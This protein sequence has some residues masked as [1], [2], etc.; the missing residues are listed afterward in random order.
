VSPEYR[1]TVPVASPALPPALHL[2]YPQ[3]AARFPLSKPKM[4][5]ALCISTI[6]LIPTLAVSSL[7]WMF[8]KNG[9]NEAVI[10][11]R[12]KVDLTVAKTE[13]A[14]GL[15]Q[16]M[17]EYELLDN[18]VNDTDKNC[19]NMQSE[20]DQSVSAAI[21]LA[22]VTVDDAVK[23]LFS[24]NFFSVLGLVFNEDFQK[25]V[26]AVGLEIF[27]L[28]KIK[29]NDEFL[30][31]VKKHDGNVPEIITALEARTFN[32]LQP[33]VEFV[34]P[35]TQLV[36][37]EIVERGNDPEFLERVKRGVSAEDVWKHLFGRIGDDKSLIS[38]Q[39]KASFDEHTC[40]KLRVEIHTIAEP[41]LTD[42][43]ML[44][45]MFER[46]GGFTANQ[47]FAAY[48][49]D[50][51]LAYA[52]LENQTLVATKRT[53][54]LVKTYL[55]I[56]DKRTVS[57]DEYAVLL[58]TLTDPVAFI[59]E[60]RDAVKAVVTF[61]MA[62]SELQRMQLQQLEI[63]AAKLEMDEKKKLELL[64]LRS[65]M[66]EVEKRSVCDVIKELAGAKFPELQSHLSDC[67]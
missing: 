41:L 12:H 65:K 43:S 10:A 26:K 29:S 39:L 36:L 8:F 24:W 2:S 49:W 33:V 57:E 62:A 19:T 6:I 15:L 14:R 3:R 58:K 46:L 34:Q 27:D 23:K 18:C 53:L 5:S 22:L 56:H 50:F 35:Q 20:F 9:Q 30:A 55:D 54:E 42:L 63:E 4:C 28:V 32:T 1:F 48:D 66:R 45:R 51:D 61:A 40:D 52:S 67:R 59:I 47:A 37:K 21:N 13:E 16:D 25:R 44:A 17:K 38:Q 7:F 11:I 60:V 31:I 64:R